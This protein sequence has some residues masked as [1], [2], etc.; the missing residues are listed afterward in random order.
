VEISVVEIV[1]L[2]EQVLALSART[3]RGVSD[4]SIPWGA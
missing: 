1:L 3:K 2:L 4:H